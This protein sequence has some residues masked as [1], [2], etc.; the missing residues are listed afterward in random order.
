MA[1]FSIAWNATSVC[2]WWFL[3]II[4]H[5]LLKT[6]SCDSYIRLK[7]CLGWRLIFRA[8]WKLKFCC[9]CDWR[10]LSVNSLTF[11]RCGYGLNLIIFKNIARI[12]ISLTFPV[13][14]SPGECQKTSLRISQL[15]VSGNGLMPD[16]IKSLSQPVL[17]KFYDAIW[18][19]LA[20]VN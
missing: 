14:L 12:D 7:R 16:N 9:W 4:Y 15:V 13:K 1:Q 17:T 20:S 5:S 6:G 19:H 2:Y 10:Q 8:I 3:L 18:C 11:G